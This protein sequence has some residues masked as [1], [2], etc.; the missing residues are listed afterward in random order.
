MRFTVPGPRK[1]ATWLHLSQM[2]PTRFS[3]PLHQPKINP[4]SSNFL[5]LS[6]PS[7]HHNVLSLK[8]SRP[9]TPTPSN[10]PLYPITTQL[11]PFPQHHFTALLHTSPAFPSPLLGNMRPFTPSS[12]KPVSEISKSHNLGASILL[13]TFQS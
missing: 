7:S 13:S 11:P 9:V 5:P 3:P 6:Q 1:L 10:F 4:S 2:G 12:T 8:P